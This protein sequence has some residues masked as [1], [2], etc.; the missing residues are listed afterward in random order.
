[1]TLTTLKLALAIDRSLALGYQDYLDACEQ[2]RRDGY[3]PHYCEHGK[4]QWVDYDN[5][6][7]PCEDGLTM[8]DPMQR[9]DFAISEAKRK[10]Q[11]ARDLMAAARTM[12][13]LM[14]GF[15]YAPVWKRLGEILSS[16][17]YR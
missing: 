10:D 15:D 13:R 11:A 17:N 16:T 3:R 4:T 9:R 2:D 8:G 5:I 7:G 14:P 6:C 1:M 12:E